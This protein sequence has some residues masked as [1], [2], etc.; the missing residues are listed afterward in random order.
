VWDAFLDLG[1]GVVAFHVP[2]AE[3]DVDGSAVA[4]ETLTR[5]YPAAKVNVGWAF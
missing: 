1:A 5:I 4:S 3:V 2:R